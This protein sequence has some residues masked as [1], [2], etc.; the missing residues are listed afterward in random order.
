M[1][2]LGSVVAISQFVSELLA[3]FLSN[4]VFSFLY[5]DVIGS[6][7]P[8]E[9]TSASGPLEADKGVV[10]TVIEPVMCGIGILAICNP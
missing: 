10:P 4:R 8:L 6:R 9:A 3:H 2:K 7:V 1:G 5:D